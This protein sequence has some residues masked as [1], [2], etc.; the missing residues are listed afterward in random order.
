M[1]NTIRPEQDHDEQLLRLMRELSKAE[2]QYVFAAKLAKHYQEDADRLGVD[3]Y[4]A[5]YQLPPA[6]EKLAAAKATFEDYRARVQ[7]HEGRYTSWS[8][9]WLVT[10][11]AGH[12]HSR[13]SC[14]TCNKGR[15]DTQFALLP[16]MSGLNDPQ[17]LVQT[18]G[19]ALCS[20]CF[21]DAPVT[22][23]DE[24]RLPTSV[25]LVLF[26][27]GEEAFRTALAAY[28]AKAAKKAA[29]ACPGSG[30]RATE[31]KWNWNYKSGVATCPS[32]GQRESTTSTGKFRQHKAK[33]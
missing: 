31:V 10:S 17:L 3:S 6:L 1:T 27:Q 12:I 32:C 29:T 7:D 4:A 26:E 15:S 23:L 9:Y 33:K 11:S 2:Q 8:R 13:R 16:S 18:V 22:W 5:Q 30:Q 28:Q 19:A 20:V 21:P 14:S 24:V 25:T